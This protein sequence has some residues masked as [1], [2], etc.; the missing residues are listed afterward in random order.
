MAAL[1]A[2][3]ARSVVRMGRYAFIYLFIYLFLKGEK[4]KEPLSLGQSLGPCPPCHLRTNCVA[5]K[6]SIAS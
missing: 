2:Q 1:K 6:A 4:L 3:C 5:A